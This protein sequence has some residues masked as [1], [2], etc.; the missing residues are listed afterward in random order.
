MRTYADARGITRALDTVAVE[1]RLLAFDGPAAGL[2]AFLTCFA[3]PAP[4]PAP[5]VP[6]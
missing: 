2:E 5:D 1:R 6:A 4:P 3:P